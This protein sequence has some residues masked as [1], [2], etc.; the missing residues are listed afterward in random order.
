MFHVKHDEAP[1]PPPAAAT[2]FGERL[3]Q[4]R[5]YAELL[6]GPGVERGLIGPRE[7]DRLW[8]RHLLNCAA[9][10]ELVGDGERVAD[11]GS[12]AGLPGIPLA[13]A[14]PALRVT[15]VEPLLRR[16]DFL[17]ETVAELGL[18]VVV[19]RGRAEDRAVRDE[20]GEFD[21]VTSRAVAALDKL[22]NW[23]LPLLRDGGR[24]LAL[25]GERAEE[26]VAEHRRALSSLGA[27][28]V[29]VVK[30]GVDYLNPPVTVVVAR[31]GARGTTTDR[32]VRPRRRS[33]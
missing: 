29:K 18:S 32:P 4:A 28:D 3:E 26:E 33:R 10:A 25:K 27:V 31:R 11:V 22:A 8:D 19:V 30:C 7:V 9:V 24:M 16:A 23:S 12:G 1:D 6:A 21:A 20:L 14:R 2:V 13:L 17:R 15:L 5:R